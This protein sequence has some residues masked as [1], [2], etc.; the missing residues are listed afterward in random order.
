MASSSE[1][2]GIGATEH[3][4]VPAGVIPIVQVAFSHDKWWCIPPEMSQEL[5]GK[6]ID[7]Q[8]AGYAW[9]WGEGGGTELNPASAN[10][11]PNPLMSRSIQASD[12]TYWRG[13][14]EVNHCATS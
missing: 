10:K 2:V 11:S 8:D 7:A 9:D 13:K 1:H 3:I 14:E 12:W 6:Y 4:G 5:C